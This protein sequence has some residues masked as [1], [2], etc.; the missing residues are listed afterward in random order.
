MSLFPRRADNAAFLRRYSALPD[1]DDDKGIDLLH[2]NDEDDNEPDDDGEVEGLIADDAADDAQNEAQNDD[3]N[4]LYR[5]S[6]D[7]ELEALARH[8]EARAAE[9][10]RDDDGAGVA[11]REAGEVSGAVREMRRA[12]AA[13][14]R[15]AEAADLARAEAQERAARLK[16]EREA[17]MMK[18]KRD[19]LTA[20]YAEDEEEVEEGHVA[21]APAIAT[22]AAAAGAAAPTTAGAAA[23]PTPARAAPEARNSEICAGGGRYRIPKKAKA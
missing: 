1:D 20:L 4:A 11:R 7:K 21:A 3:L 6:E 18:R 10:G 15:K 5:A 19:A 16:R 9:Y 2:D 22:L 12:A 13:A 8:F 14:A 17:A 23:M